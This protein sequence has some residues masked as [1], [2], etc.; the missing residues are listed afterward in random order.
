[1]TQISPL[2]D[3]S[4]LRLSGEDTRSFLQ[5]IITN[6]INA[7]KPD[8]ALFA[9][10]L[11]PQGKF[12]HDFFLYSDGDDILLETESALSESLHKTLKR[13]KL[14]AAV[15][16]TDE[17]DTWHVTAA[18]NGAP[19][20]VP[21][22]YADPRHADMGYRIL[23]NELNVK[24]FY[25]LTSTATYDDYERHRLSLGVPDGSRDASERAVIMELNYDQL[26]AIS[27]T[28]G[29]YVGQEVT[30]R[31]HYR[32][33][34]R[35]CLYIVRADAPLPPVGTDITL[36]GGGK[37]V[38]EIRSSQ[39]NLGLALVRVESS[40]SPLYTGDSK[41]SAE[42]PFYM[43]EKIAAIQTAEANHPPA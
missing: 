13:Y 40:A 16:I 23:S 41:L 11:S 30:A 10:M 27:F 18:W 12:Q 33:I 25:H 22:C 4:V 21:H 28:K 32:H 39:G 36:Q 38:G 6:D 5:G 37:A 1:M 20:V 29:C 42:L 35:K 8:S 24:H 9:A 7:L 17:S 34:L 3:R 19:P 31:M 26:N 15:T 43:Q 14:R 2:P